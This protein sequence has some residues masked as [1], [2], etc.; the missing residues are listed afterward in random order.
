MQ[1]STQIW[2]MTQE[3]YRVNP[4]P[5]RIQ[6]ACHVLVP[7]PDR[8]QAGN[9]LNPF[10]DMEHYTPHLN[11]FPDRSEHT[12]KAN[13]VL[14][15]LNIPRKSFFQQGYKVPRMRTFSGQ[16]WT[17]DQDTW[18]QRTANRSFNSPRQETPRCRGSN[19]RPENDRN[20]G[21][22]PRHVVTDGT[23]SWTRSTCPAVENKEATSG[24]IVPEIEPSKSRNIDLR[25]LDL[26]TLKLL[27][28][29]SNF[30]VWDPR[31]SQKGSTS[32]KWGLQKPFLS[33]DCI[34]SNKGH[35]HSLWTGNNWHNAQT[36][37]LGKIL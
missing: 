11:P 14:D 22:G 18:K 30:S 31:Q 26:R 16:N 32:R 19:L 3:G 13:P 27:E 20:K 29:F 15:A 1:H 6:I 37:I 10:P 33:T 28:S 2:R 8:I 4:F 34:D 17:Q 7:F 21:P 36:V 35:G 5:D 12:F 25:N 23:T 9:D 24:S